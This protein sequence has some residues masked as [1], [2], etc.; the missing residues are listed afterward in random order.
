M[1]SRFKPSPPA[2]SSPCSKKPLFIFLSSKYAFGEPALGDYH[3]PLH[4]QNW[5]PNAIVW[6]YFFCY[7]HQA[8]RKKKKK[9][10]SALGFHKELLHSQS[11]YKAKVQ[12]GC[13]P[14]FCSFS[15][16]CPLVELDSFLVLTVG[17]L[18]FEEALSR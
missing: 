3:T 9:F 10:C 13:R 11:N 18:L 1:E 17:C 15:L 5:Q 4:P 14:S 8:R 12:L 2:S 7:L 6:I 16:A